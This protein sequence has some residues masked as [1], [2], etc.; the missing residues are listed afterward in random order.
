MPSDLFTTSSLGSYAGLVA[1]TFLLV[2][3]FKDPVRKYLGDWFVRL[4]AV[5]IAF[6]IQMFVLY[7]GTNVT[8]ETAGLGLLNA[9]LVAITAAGAHEM[10]K[11]KLVS[12]S[13][14]AP[15]PPT[16]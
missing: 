6:G 16:V 1:A 10:T 3:F 9:F 8:V 14:D 2:S 12:A 4:L 5:V 11:P 7:V 15:R 13:P